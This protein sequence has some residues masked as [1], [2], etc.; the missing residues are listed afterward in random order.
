MSKH[1]PGPWEIHEWRQSSQ[2]GVTFLGV[3]N[4]IHQYSAD[5]TNHMLRICA[6]TETLKTSQT[7]GSFEGFH[8][9]DIQI[10][11]GK[12][13]YDEAIANARL[14]AE[15]PKMHDELA[16]LRSLLSDAMKALEPLVSYGKYT[17]PFDDVDRIPA[18]LLVSNIR[19][20]ADTY[21]RIKAAIGGE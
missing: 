5:A 11:Y 21:A 18:K 6:K 3:Q 10:L 8:I 14:I 19:A 9:A 17:K 13:G 12:D 16:A 1:T 20:A 15:A 4:G 2:S 7:F